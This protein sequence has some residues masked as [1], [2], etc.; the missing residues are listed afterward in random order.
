MD[1]P[2]HV[3]VAE[4]LGCKPVYE[5]YTV[6]GSPM[7]GPIWRCLCPKPDEVPPGA[8]DETWNHE[9][10]PAK[11]RHIGLR[12]SGLAVARYDES[13]FSLG[14][15]IERLGITLKQE[16]DLWHA[17]ER[18]SHAGIEFSSEGWHDGMEADGPTPLVAACRL[19]LSLHGAGKLTL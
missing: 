8:W 6:M 19:I 14:P 12:A 18:D 5:T 11:P 10:L 17:C 4:A 16:G 15:W 13:W 7:R 1:K 2:L 3:Q 9:K